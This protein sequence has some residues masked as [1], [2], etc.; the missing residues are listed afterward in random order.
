MEQLLRV[1]GDYVGNVYVLSRSRGS[2]GARERV[3]RV[4]GSGL[5]DLVRRQYPES[6]RKV[7]I[8]GGGAPHLRWVREELGVG[9]GETG[10]C[11]VM[12]ASACGGGEGGRLGLVDPS[13]PR[14]PRT[15][16]T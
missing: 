10:G 7:R 8:W 12:W 15:P 2:H 13:T 14:T 4:L 9:A 11:D 5:F 3:G 6:L 16:R 1:A